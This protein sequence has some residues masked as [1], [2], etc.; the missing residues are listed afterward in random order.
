MLNR[1]SGQNLSGAV[2][3]T[4]TLNGRLD[5]LAANGTINSN[6]LAVGDKKIDELKLIVWRDRECA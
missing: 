3:G 2:G 6:Y 5:A 1:M 4:V